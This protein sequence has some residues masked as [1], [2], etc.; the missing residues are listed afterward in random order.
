MSLSNGETDSVR[1]T[2]AKRTGRDLNTIRV[3]SLRVTRG[4]G[5]N[6]TELLE[7]VQGELVAEEVEEDVLE[8][9]TEAFSGS[10]NVCVASKDLR[11]STTT[12][13]QESRE[14]ISGDRNAPV[15]ENETIA[16]KPLRVLGVGIEEANLGHE[17]IVSLPLSAYIPGEQDVS[18][19]RHAHRST[20]E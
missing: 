15:G 7:V 10:D 14:I 12:K 17:H 20:C 3:S 2:L 9:A 4:Q 5:V 6:L 11:V 13:S 18:D 16:V 19:R 1:E 8:R